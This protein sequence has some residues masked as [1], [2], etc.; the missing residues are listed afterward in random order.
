MNRDFL[1]RE[2]GAV[3]FV[4]TVVLGGLVVLTSLLIKAAGAPPAP[5]PSPCP[6][7]TPIV[8]QLTPRPA[9]SGR[10]PGAASPRVSPSPPV[11]L[12]SVP[13]GCPQPS[14]IVQTPPPTATPSAARPSPSPP[15]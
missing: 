11:A 14:V 4:L 6:S 5:P 3:T 2:W 12:P 1:R 10:S 9:V 15:T 13:Y 7:V 8:V